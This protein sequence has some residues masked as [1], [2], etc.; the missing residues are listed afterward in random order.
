MGQK[1][2]AFLTQ[3]VQFWWGDC[4]SLKQNGAGDYTDTGINTG[5][6]VGNWQA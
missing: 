1:S 2:Q 6:K 3:L 4:V 5:I